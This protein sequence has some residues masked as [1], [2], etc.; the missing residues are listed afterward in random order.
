[1]K[2]KG[3]CSNY[4]ILG[5][6][7]LAGGYEM[8][9]SGTT[10]NLAN[11]RDLKPGRACVEAFLFGRDYRQSLLNAYAD[12]LFISSSALVSG[13]CDERACCR[14][15][16]L[17]RDKSF[18]CGVSEHTRFETHVLTNG[19]FRRTDNIA[20]ES[21]GD[22]YLALSVLLLENR[23]KL[24]R[25]P[26]SVQGSRRPS[27]GPAHALRCVRPKWCVLVERFCKEISSLFF[28]GSNA[29]S[30]LTCLS[31]RGVGLFTL[32]PMICMTPE[33]MVPS[34]RRAATNFRCESIYKAEGYSHSALQYWRFL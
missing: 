18:A 11:R 15:L 3:G 29:H 22:M 6:L 25:L 14:R 20:R 19:N 32:K 9:L 2:M 17:A 30:V 4:G 16:K 27:S 12:P 13:L 23:L 10:S 24:K 21:I 1:M 5:E 34:A 8:L 28:Q 7:N 26:V 33:G 31:P